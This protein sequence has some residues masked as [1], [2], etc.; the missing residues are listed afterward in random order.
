M[1]KRGARRVDRKAIKTISMDSV[2]RVR[3]GV[4]ISRNVACYRMAWTIRIQ[5]MTPLEVGDGTA[6]ALGSRKARG[7]S[8]RLTQQQTSQGRRS[9]EDRG[10]WQY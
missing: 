9:V 4:D 7:T 2:A 6:R 8:L 5:L 1:G 3:A 10:Q